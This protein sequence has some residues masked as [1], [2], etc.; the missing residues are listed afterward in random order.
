[1]LKMNVKKVLTMKVFLK[2]DNAER[3]KIRFKILTYGGVTTF[4]IWYPKLGWVD[5]DEKIIL[6]KST[7]GIYSF[8]CKSGENRRKQFLR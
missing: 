7:T 8:L 3:W 5:F 4:L 1:M 6:N 2:K